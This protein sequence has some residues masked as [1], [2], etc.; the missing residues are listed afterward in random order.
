MLTKLLL[1]FCLDT[2]HAND[3]KLN[4]IYKEILDFK[5]KNLPYSLQIEKYLS[6]ESEIEK[7]GD[8][9]KLVMDLKIKDKYPNS[10]KATCTTKMN[11]KEPLSIDRPK[12]QDSVNWCFDYAGADL[13][14]NVTGEEPS[15]AFL[16]LNTLKYFNN[17][18]D[19]FIG[20]VVTGINDHGTCLE[21]SF[22][23]SDYKFSEKYSDFDMAS[24]NDELMKFYNAISEDKKTKEDALKLLCSNEKLSTALSEI[25]PEMPNSKLL[26]LILKFN[27]SE[28]NYVLAT[29]I[30]TECPVKK[31]PSLSKYSVKYINYLTKSN[32]S[33][34]DK[35]L[36]NG[37]IV[38]IEYDSGILKD[39]NY[40]ADSLNGHASTLI[41]RRWNQKK[42]TCEFLLR[43][44][45]GKPCS[46]YHE[47]YECNNGHIWISESFFQYSPNIKRAVY[48]EKSK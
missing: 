29:L 18:A 38:A 2:A 42:N 21:K 46:N 5:T 35:V 30:N 22:N 24:L 3:E 4:A 19:G 32:W 34:L 16:G 15:A 17:Q 13:V 45:W 6:R 44:S 33:Q 31:I 11:L 43:N 23:S 26:D 36:S 37:G 1:L 39:Y 20:K 40:G 48:L 27:K 25:F 9:H 41:G 28:N 8:Q 12:N 7:T 14:A 47:D 10:R